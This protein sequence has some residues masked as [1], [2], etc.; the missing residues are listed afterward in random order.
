MLALMMII[1]GVV[2]RLVPHLPNFAPISA[3]ALFGGAYLN[4]RFALLIP[5]VA[6]VISDYLLLYV[7]PFRVPI[8]DF[9]RIYPPDAMFHSTTFYVWGS[10]M[11]SGLIGLWL[12]K[13]KKPV[14][15][16][17]ASLATSVQFFLITNFGVW[18]AG[19]YARDLS[20]LAQSYIMGLPFFRG[21]F[22]GDRFYTA[23]FFGA[24]ELALKF[25]EK[26]KLATA[27]N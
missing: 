9:S 15:I 14:Y 18:A 12:R 23:T 27:R 22:V 1:G 19:A 16:I 2:L 20:G 17:G 8:V 3:T 21:T 10:F 4:K 5:L 24:Y 26:P 13:R 25:A 11:I 7:N 6:M